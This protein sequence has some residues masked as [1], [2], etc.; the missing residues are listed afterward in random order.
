[1]TTI[2][3][4]RNSDPFKKYW[5]V[6]LL[7]FSGVGVWA[8]YP[9]YQSGQGLNDSAFGRNLMAVKQSLNSLN[10]PEGAPGSPLGVPS[11]Q[12]SGQGAYKKEGSAAMDGLFPHPAEAKKAAAKPRSFADDLAAIAGL[13]GRGAG[14]ASA[15]SGAAAPAPAVPMEAPSLGSGFSNGSG[16][17]GGGTSA[18]YTPPPIAAL[19][20]GAGAFN[21]GQTQTS[22]Q[23]ASDLSGQGG[24]NGGNAMAALQAAAKGAVES[25]NA[26]SNAAAASGLSS[27]FDGLRASGQIGAMGGQNDGGV[28]IG[29]GQTPMNLKANPKDLMTK[30]IS[31]P[32]P[33]PVTPNSGNMMM[34]MMMMMLPMLMMGMMGA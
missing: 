6:L 23:N 30:K 33:A 19:G 21:E 9:S 7:I 24:P 12:G 28:G 8:S 2:K 11:G 29:G 26:A 25:A 32:M 22:L 14:G 5:W 31:P 3:F 18:S 10:N 20:S 15:L 13:H 34:Q 27:N 17:S 4:S 1:M 16:T